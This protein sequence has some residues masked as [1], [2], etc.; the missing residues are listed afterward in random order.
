MFTM[1]TSC[2]F[3][4]RIP[5]CCHKIDVNQRY[6]FYNFN[7]ECEQPK[8]YKALLFLSLGKAEEKAW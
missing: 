6:K 2:C 5:D 4:D 8:N 3:G 7:R 1:F